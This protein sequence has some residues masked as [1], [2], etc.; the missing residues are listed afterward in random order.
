MSKQ[1]TDL[2]ERL[3][4]AG[5]SVL[6]RRL[7][8]AAGAERPARELSERMARAIGISMVT[9]GSAG[10][11]SVKTD[12]G[13]PAVKATSA[14]TWLVPWVSGALLAVGLVVGILVANHPGARPSA[15]TTVR[16]AV[17]SAPAAS[18][19]LAQPVPAPARTAEVPPA[20]SDE[21]LPRVAVPASARSRRET[22]AGELAD[23]IA[24]VDAARSALASGGAQ[25]A[26]AIV[27]DYQSQY[28]SGTFRP[29]VSA[30]KIEALIK[31]GRTAEARTLAQRFVVAYGPGPLA[32]RVA[33]L[34]QIPAP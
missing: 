17:S 18:S 19:A 1:E 22:P 9:G 24:L 11:E 20:G 34:A 3:R 13:V 30:V 16:T 28:P 26:L 10:T 33:R 14:S 21:P 5:A 2:P 6:E 8:E 23:Q 12:I 32:A 7:L 27:R 29:E 4:A 31:M 25:R 15:A